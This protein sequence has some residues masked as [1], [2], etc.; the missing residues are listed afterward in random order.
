MKV[1]IVGGVA[2]GATAATRIR[3]LDEKAEIIII[4]RT[5]YISY[6]NCGLP[7]YIGGVIKD[8][9]ALT[10]Q[11]PESFKRRFN[12]DVRVKQE[13]VDINCV[14]K[15]VLIKNLITG[16]LYKEKYDK[17][18]LSPGAKPIK[19]NLKGI[20]SKRIFSL[21][22]VED[23]FKIKDYILENKIESIVVIG[24]GF[25]GLET[26]ENVFKLGIKTTLI[27]K[28]NQ[29]MNIID[30]DMATL[31]HSKLRSEGINLKLSSNVV[32]FEEENNAINVLLEND[33]AIKTNLVIMAIG[34][35]PETSLA[36]NI[37]LKLGI[38]DTIEVN[39]LMETSIKDIYAVG[40]AVSIKHLITGK[41][42][43]IPLAGPANKQA[44][45][46]ADNICGF[47]S[48]YKGTMGSSIIK[49]FDMTVASTGINE[50]MAKSL[51]INFESVVLSP[52]SHA[53]YYPNA[54]VMTM[55]VIFNKDSLDILGAQIIGYA[56]VDKRLDVI[57]TAMSAKMK[58]TELKDL[59]LCYAPPY[60]SAKDPINMAGFIIDN[61]VTNKI[62]QFHYQDLD[63][64]LNDDDVILLDVRTIL[65]YSSSHID[66]FIN[67]PLDDLRERINEL[68]NKKKVYVICQSG[69]RS[70][71]ACRILLQN[72]FDCYNFSGGYRFYESIVKDK[73]LVK[74]SLLCGMD[75]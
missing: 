14:D 27:Q 16:D 25:I 10:L 64:L 8:K 30:Y 52:S 28:Q 45:I 67:I 40:D 66:K 12:I 26:A 9:K 15:T 55:K 46:A 68:D 62:K 60:S 41:D 29:L 11:T 65:E 44:R 36:K 75:V 39:D 23:T 32:G 20:D 69:I 1:V 2:G 48:H 21:R 56:G 63:Y 57:A 37:G 5:N 22:T 42:T 34:V 58:A 35:M 71:L 17:L 73:V 33:N 24:G 53:S 47:N 49:L 13:V 70:Y 50:E 72:G 31:L 4:E 7:Y 43:S 51:N 6:A 19:P 18:L 3:R 59:E 61:I 74:E 54:K 38:K